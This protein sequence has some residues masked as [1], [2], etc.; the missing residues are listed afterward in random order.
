MKIFLLIEGDHS[1]HTKLGL[2]VL[3][4]LLSFMLIEKVFPDGAEGDDDEEEHDEDVKV[5][6]KESVIINY[7][8]QRKKN[9]MTCPLEK[10]CEPMAKCTDSRCVKC[11]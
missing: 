7:Y 11:M 4:G 5:K 6:E 10:K 9:R 1:A 3:A 8:R 2:W